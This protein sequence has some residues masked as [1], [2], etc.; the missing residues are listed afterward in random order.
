MVL[1][2]GPGESVNA[3]RTWKEQYGLTY[4]VLS[5]PDSAVYHSYSPGPTH[6]VPH[7]AVISCDDIL[8]YT[9]VG[10]N[11]TQVINAIETELEHV[12][13]IQHVP[14]FDTE[15]TTYPIS[16][17]ASFSTIPDFLPGY[18]KL[19]WKH[20][21]DEFYTEVRMSEAKWTEY[22][23]EIPAQAADTII[24]YYIQVDN[25]D[26]CGRMEP[27]PGPEAP[28]S[29]RIG[30]DTTPPDI[31]HN[32][33]SEASPAY[34]PLPIQATVTDN[35]GI[36]SVTLEYRVNDDPFQ[37]VPMTGRGEY[38]AEIADSVSPGDQIDYRII[39]VDGA[40]NPNTTYHP[41]TGYHTISVIQSVDALVID[42]DS[43]HDS[44]PMISNNLQALGYSVSEVTQV[45]ESLFA[46]KS[47]WICLGM[48]SGNH[49]LSADEGAQLAAFLDIGGSIYMEGGDTW[50]YDAPTDVHP[51]FHINGIDDG[52]SDAGPID[53][54]SGTFTQNMHFNYQTTQH[55]NNYVDHLAPTEGAV[56]LLKNGSPNYN[57]AILYEAN[58]RTIGSSTKLGGL[59]QQVSGASPRDLISG[60][61]NFLAGAPETTP[62]PTPG[63]PTPG[64]PTPTPVNPTAT[65]AP[66]TNTPV[67]PTATTVPPT[68]TPVPPTSTSVP[69]SPT[70]QPPTSTPVEP[71]ST[72]TTPPTET[73]T[74]DTEAFVKL[75]LNKTD[76]TSGDDFML[77]VEIYN[78]RETKTLQEYI[79]LDVFGISYYFWPGWTETPDY[80]D[81][82][83][84]PGFHE[85]D[86][87]LNF[88]WPD[89]AGAADGLKFWG[90]LVDVDSIYG[91]FDYV[92]W[93]YH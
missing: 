83:L 73:P 24:D 38:S 27:Y 46:Y 22:S 23:A 68:N 41:E 80:Q 72:P 43:Y 30:I 14:M 61:M 85:T 35:L 20:D 32:P 6:Y 18:P 52:H 76:F 78:P 62:T 69:P 21:P 57:V 63:T 5:D 93:S 16:I 42:L 36:A 33:V 17:T 19:F 48:Y 64:T 77:D 90:A 40:Q 10:F 39:A 74:P 75:H 4:P 67:P 84:T 49:V 82:D 2:I 47:I 79:L 59:I 13:G 9:A 45:P 26:H 54:N 60:M 58:Y 1:S 87:I 31:S 37:Q 8:G 25:T 29:F 3:C 7:N 11:E 34:F 50:A 28:Y 56:I 15:N 55:Y 12:V 44:G 70:P 51:Y 66:P 92:E 86:H 88:T 89:N 65:T 91:N 71:S 81:I 53:G